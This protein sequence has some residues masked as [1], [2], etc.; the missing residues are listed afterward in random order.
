MARSIYISIWTA[1][2]WTV[3]RA[4]FG[5]KSLWSSTLKSLSLIWKM[6]SKNASFAHFCKCGHTHR[7][8][9]FYIFI[10]KISQTHFKQKTHAC[11]RFRTL[12]LERCSLK[13][14]II[15]GLIWIWRQKLDY[16]ARFLYS[17]SPGEMTSGWIKLNSQKYVHFHWNS[18][19]L[20]FSENRYITLKRSPK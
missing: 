9:T 10:H 3:T 6:I 8:L 15:N 18:N 19:M 2:L 12:G 17:Y 16:F 20:N 7:N 11:P 4:N 13:H 1:Q 5:H 14:S